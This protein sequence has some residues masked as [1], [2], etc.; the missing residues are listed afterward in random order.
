MWYNVKCAPSVFGNPPLKFSASAEGGG[1]SGGEVWKKSMTKVSVSPSDVVTPQMQQNFDD[2][3]EKSGN[4]G[5]AIEKAIWNMMS[6]ELS[7]QMKQQRWIDLV[8]GKSSSITFEGGGGL[9]GIP[10]VGSGVESMSIS[11]SGGKTTTTI[12]MGNSLL[13]Q[14]ISILRGSTLSSGGFTFTGTDVVNSAS[15]PKFGKMSRG[16]F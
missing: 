7:A 8:T 1:S 11:V 5:F 15:N 2:Y 14:L 4:P 9:S 6:A 10:S 13:K 3:E 16:G 12:N